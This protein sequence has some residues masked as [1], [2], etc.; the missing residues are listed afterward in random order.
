MDPGLKRGSE[1]TQF[2]KLGQ[3]IGSL[4]E[5][6]LLYTSFLLTLEVL[7]NREQLVALRV[8]KLNKSFIK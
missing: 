3:Y 2:L 8:L 7:F 6:V 1:L 5:G 4:E